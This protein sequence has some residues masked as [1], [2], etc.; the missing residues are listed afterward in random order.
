M[1]K[2][3]VISAWLLLGCGSYQMVEAADPRAQA[4]KVAAG[5]TAKSIAKMLN[6]SGRE[7]MDIG[8]LSQSTYIKAA[9][10]VTGILGRIGVA[11]IET[12]EA[13]KI[14]QMIKIHGQKIEASHLASI[15]VAS[16][17]DS[18][19]SLLKQ[20]IDVKGGDIIARAGSSIATAVVEDV[21]S[22]QRIT[23]KIT[24]D[25]VGKIDPG[26]LGQIGVTRVSH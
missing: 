24:L 16:V 26:W 9:S 12:V 22:R 1:K 4:V 14:V 7:K 5:L 18:E 23:Q 15:G 10:L 8:T 11:E 3:M 25:V 20:H 2:L 13:L 17:K 19:L 21:E 6:S